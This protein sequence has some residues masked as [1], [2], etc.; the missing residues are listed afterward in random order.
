MLQQVQLTINCTSSCPCFTPFEPLHLIPCSSCYSKDLPLSTRSHQHRPKKLK[1]RS[2]RVA[3]DGSGNRV[4]GLECIAR[5]TIILTR[6]ARDVDFQLRLQARRCKKRQRAIAPRWSDVNCD[7]TITG[8][9]SD[10]SEP[11]TCCP[12]PPAADPVLMGSYKSCLLA[13]V[14]TMVSIKPFNALPV[15]SELSHETTMAQFL[16]MSTAL[17]SQVMGPDCASWTLA[18]IF[19]D[20]TVMILKFRGL[21]TRSWTFPISRPR[22]KR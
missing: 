14:L 7:Q 18:M 5:S 1:H 10:A 19:F 3:W 4:K 12:P 6:P 11:V 13:Y 22:W 16:P 8:W 21:D 15:T 9:D 20:G 17:L 2:R